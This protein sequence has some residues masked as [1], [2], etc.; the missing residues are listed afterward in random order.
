MYTCNNVW[1]ESRGAWMI[2]ITRC[3]TV[4]V[5]MMNRMEEIM[6]VDHFHHRSKVL[7]EEE[8]Q[9]KLRELDQAVLCLG[10]EECQYFANPKSVFS[11]T[12]HQRLLCIYLIGT[13]LKKIRGI[14]SSN[15][16]LKLLDCHIYANC[17]LW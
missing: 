6:Y 16:L 8:L 2:M 3:I 7:L 10:L 14:V 15:M 9:Q 1:R 17:S 12:V 11:Q 13:I 5:L 4:Q